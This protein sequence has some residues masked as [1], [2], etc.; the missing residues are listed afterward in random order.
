MTWIA[1]ILTNVYSGGLIGVRASVS[2]IDRFHAT[3]NV[4]IGGRPFITDGTALIRNDGTVCIDADTDKLIT[5]RGVYINRITLHEKYIQ[6]HARIPL[7]GERIVTL[8]EE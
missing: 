3:L 7:L 1:A 6:V 4:R 5:E 2:T 8:K